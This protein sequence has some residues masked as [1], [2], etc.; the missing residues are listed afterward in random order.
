MIGEQSWRGP[1]DHAVQ[2]HEGRPAAADDVAIPR[3]SPPATRNS[4]D[5]C[6]VDER[7]ATR[8]GEGHAEGRHAEAGGGSSRKRQMAMLAPPRA[9]SEWPPS[10]ISHHSVSW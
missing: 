2:P 3:Q 8:I 7:I 1:S 9:G 10:R 6:P 5:V 4:M